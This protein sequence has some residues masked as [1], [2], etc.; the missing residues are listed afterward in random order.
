[1]EKLLVQALDIITK[2][3]VENLEDGSAQRLNDSYEL[4]SYYPDSETP[5]NYYVVRD[6]EEGEEVVV[7]QFGEDDKLVFTSL[8]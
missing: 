6:I 2:E 8:I 1:M 4:Y 5:I 7:V 3:M